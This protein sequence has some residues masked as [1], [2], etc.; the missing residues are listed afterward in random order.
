M[1][2]EYLNAA[3]D[4]A[5][6]TRLDDGEGYFGSIPELPGVWANEDTIEATRADLREALEGWVVL[7]LQLGLP[8]PEVDGVDLT[9]Q[10]A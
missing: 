5:V 7:R 10:V 2:T 6:F 8:I 9:F 1:L 4:H 3:L